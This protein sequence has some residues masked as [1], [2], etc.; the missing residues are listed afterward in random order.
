[1]KSQWETRNGD[2]VK[3]EYTIL[4]PDGTRRIVSYTADKH[5]GFNAVVKNVKDI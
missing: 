4:E 5:N 2:E 1:M 3:G